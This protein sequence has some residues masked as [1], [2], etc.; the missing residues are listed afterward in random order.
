MNTILN[1]EKEES[2]KSEMELAGFKKLEI[3][4]DEARLYYLVGERSFRNAINGAF[5]Y[6]CLERDHLNL[7]KDE[8]LRLCKIRRKEVVSNNLACVS[9]YI[10]KTGQNVEIT[11]STKE[12]MKRDIVE[13]Y[14]REPNQSGRFFFTAF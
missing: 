7:N 2:I 14:S 6:A 3:S 11:T 8:F 9:D 10:R 5:E 4:S 1:L 13:N 12:E